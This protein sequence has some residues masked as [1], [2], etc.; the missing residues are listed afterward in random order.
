MADPGLPLLI[1]ARVTLRPGT[2]PADLR[3]L[4]A[5]PSVTRWWGEP[6][7]LDELAAD[8]AG[9]T[10]DRLL[11]IEAAGQTV[12]GI[13]YSE[14]SDPMY[15]HASIDIFLGEAG[16]GRGLGR[17]AVAL[18]AQWLID[19]QRHHRLTIDPAA[20]NTR[21]IRCYRAVGFQP[22]G[23]LRSYERGLDGLLRDG[24]LMDLLAAELVRPS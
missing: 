4:L 23:I 11:L 15:R 1:G 12:G 3:T 14:V 7:P 18:L 20:D 5:E 17:E 22:V 6:A 2:D 13:Q 8:L 16:Q 19:E 21:A 9:A 24:L 10:E